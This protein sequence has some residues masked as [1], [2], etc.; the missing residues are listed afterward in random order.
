MDW[1]RTRLR[2]SRD[3][4]TGSGNTDDCGDTPT[5]VA[6]L[7]SSAHDVNLVQK[8]VITVT[9]DRSKTGL[10]IRFQCNQK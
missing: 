2:S 5:L 4:L 10:Y 9:I 3:L 1:F 6:S 8:G 7:E